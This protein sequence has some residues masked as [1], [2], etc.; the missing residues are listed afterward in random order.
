MNPEKQ[1]ASRTLLVSVLLSAPGPVVMGIG[2]T[3]GHSSTQ[4]ADFIRRTA[5]LAS[6]II[7]YI[8]Y[9]KTNRSEN[10]E[11]DRKVR[12]ERRGNIFTGLTMCLS[13]VTM[14]LLALLSDTPNKG[15]V[16]IGLIIAFLGTVTNTILWRRYMSLYRR[17]G[18]A[19][20]RAEAR[21]YGAKS[22]VDFFVTAALASVLLFPA[23]PFSSF[24]DTAGS[25]LV[26]LYLLYCGLRT[27]REQPKK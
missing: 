24:L 15:N 20:L 11:E 26:S 27:I 16:T 18:N 2:L 4:I 22:A 1:S 5:E 21:L 8:I 9:T 19:I 3:M 12:L 10:T 14:L 6:L 23:T 17:Q 13:G 7:A 25:V